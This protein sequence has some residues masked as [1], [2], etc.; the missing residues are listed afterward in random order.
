MQRLTEQS[1]QQALL[2]FNKKNNKMRQLIIDQLPENPN[3]SSRKIA[4]YPKVSVRYFRRY[5]RKLIA[6]RLWKIVCLLIVLTAL[7]LGEAYHA[8]QEKTEEIIEICMQFRIH[9]DD[10]EDDDDKTLL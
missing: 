5:R 8:K 7:F 1:N 6:T 10:D 3:I 9:E 4:G 2:L